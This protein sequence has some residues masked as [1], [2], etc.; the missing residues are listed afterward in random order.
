MSDEDMVAMLLSIM[1][2]EGLNHSTVTVTA[3]STL[4]SSTMV[5]VSTTSWSRNTPVE[6]GE[7]VTLGGGTEQQTVNLY[8]LDTYSLTL[9]GYFKYITY[10]I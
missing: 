6:G 4:E 10:V 8:P 1:V 5:Q 9:D 2:D 7:R 3:L